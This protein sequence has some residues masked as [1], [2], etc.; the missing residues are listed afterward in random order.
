MLQVKKEL[1]VCLDS[2][3][4]PFLQWQ[5]SMSILATRLPMSLRNEVCLISCMSILNNSFDYSLS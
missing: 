4:L 3:E 1:L 2:P 5:E